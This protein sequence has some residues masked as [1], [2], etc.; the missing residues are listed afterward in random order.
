MVDTQNETF[1]NLPHEMC[2][3]SRNNRLI[4]EWLTFYA[5][6]NVSTQTDS[7]TIQP[8]QVQIRRG[9]WNA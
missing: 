2:A 7:A 1:P 3:P 8:A 6:E 5:P 9:E 4:S